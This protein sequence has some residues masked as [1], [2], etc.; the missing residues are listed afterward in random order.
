MVAGAILFAACS[1]FEHISSPDLN[2]DLVE[3]VV[4]E[5]PGFLSGDDQPTTKAS[6]VPS[7][8]DLGFAWEATDTVGIYPD[9]G[10]Q[11]Y[12]SMEKGVGT[13]VATFDGGGW[14]LKQSST[15]SCY[16]PFV[17]NIYL[18][19]DRIPVSFIGQTQKSPSDFS[20]ALYILVSEGTSSSNGGLRFTFDK[21]NTIIRIDATLPVGSYTKASLTVEDP[22]F[23]TKGFYSLSEKKIV[24]EEFSQTLEIG[25]VDFTLE[26]ESTAHIYISSAPVNLKGKQVTVRVFSDDGSVFECVKTPS[27]E[28]EANKWY[29]LTCPLQEKQPNNVIYYTSQEDIIVIPNAPDVFG[30]NIVSNE[31]VKGKGIITFDGEVTSIGASAFYNNTA[32]TSIK[33]PDSVSSIGAGAFAGCESLSSFEGKFSA[34]NGRCLIIDNNIVAVAPYELAN[35]TIPSSVERIGDLAF[36]F[37]ES[38]K[39]VTIEEGVSYIGHSSFENCRALSSIIIPESV[40]SIGSKAFSGC[41][42]LLSITVKSVNPPSL[43][44]G[45]NNGAFDSTNDCPIYVAA[46]SVDAY[47]SAWI[48]YADRIQPIPENPAFVDLGLSVMWASCNLGAYS[49][50]EEGDF[51]AWGEVET[52]PTYQ[53]DNYKWCSSASSPYNW[54]LGSDRFSKYNYGFLYG[55]IDNNTVL[56]I[57]D[58]AAHARLGANWRIPSSDEFYE[59]IDNC[60]IETV[61]VNGV[62]G[63][64]FTS[65]INGNNIFL[66]WTGSS[67]LNSSY[68]SS[69]LNFGDPTYAKAFQLLEQG[70]YGVLTSQ[71]SKGYTIRPV[72]ESPISS[73]PCFSRN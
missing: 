13:N 42:S 14:S 45:S 60:T 9:K 46:E 31:Y 52:K 50:E 47:K 51:Y 66:P 33:I 55:E 37:C 24:G 7:E 69:N 53:W 56:T 59:L 62:T 16:Y 8:E 44:Y 40:T 63:R 22:L 18:D 10:A 34:D 15:Y 61:S 49:P 38:L 12:F 32:L 64:K 36:S 72:Y 1:E 29:Y 71:R 2:G 73:R 35:Y 20:D 26:E 65:K 5:V 4:F 48:I 39:S 17:G 23:I 43:E 25:L 68:W 41:S 70:R 58:D 67:S 30:A 3:K 21:L 11:I 28:Y 57:E 6:H 54:N 27:R 19:R